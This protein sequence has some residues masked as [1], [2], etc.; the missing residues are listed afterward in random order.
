MLVRIWNNPQSSRPLLSPPPDLVPD[1]A[2]VLQW[3]RFGA[4]DHRFSFLLWRFLSRVS[5][6]TEQRSHSLRLH[7]QDGVCVSDL[8]QVSEGGGGR[9][10]SIGSQSTT[11][12]FYIYCIIW[13]TYS[14]LYFPSYWLLL[15]YSFVVRNGV[16]VT[17]SDTFIMLVWSNQQSK[18]Q[19]YHKYIKIIQSKSCIKM[20]PTFCISTEIKLNTTLIAAI[21]RS[22]TQ[23]IC[24][25]LSLS[26]LLQVPP[27][28]FMVTSFRWAPMITYWTERYAFLTSD[29]TQ[30]QNQMGCDVD[31]PWAVSGE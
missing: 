7:I 17:Q 25:C 14:S 30:H 6:Q 8:L 26:R 22:I 20:R 12:L 4:V 10:Q 27:V 28:G 21:N 29:A 16:T 1:H 19:H 31:I 9:R 11:T 5:G 24:V 3:G 18:A 13:G 23:S 2:A 15:Y